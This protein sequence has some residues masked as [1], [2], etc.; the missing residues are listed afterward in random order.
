M[1]GVSIVWPGPQAPLFLFKELA[2]S[3]DWL[4]AGLVAAAQ[5]P[6]EPCSC[7]HQVH[8]WA[9]Q[10]QGVNQGVFVSRINDLL[11]EQL[12]PR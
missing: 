2:A 12:L 4:A 11:M 7:I 10:Q 1:T 3:H 5:A 6:C 8:G 9:Y